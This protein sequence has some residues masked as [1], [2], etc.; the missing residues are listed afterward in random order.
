M[1]M[2]TQKGLPGNP[3]KGAKRIANFVSEIFPDQAQSAPYCLGPADESMG[4]V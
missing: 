2:V 1:E 3:I 4:A